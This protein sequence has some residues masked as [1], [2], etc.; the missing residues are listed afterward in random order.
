[1]QTPVRP[2]AAQK[3]KEK[4]RIWSVWEILFN[5]IAVR[6]TDLQK[7]LVKVKNLKKLSHSIANGEYDLQKRLVKLTRFWM[8]A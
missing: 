6:D 5:S 1:M 3:T 7:R 8:N 2:R 4:L